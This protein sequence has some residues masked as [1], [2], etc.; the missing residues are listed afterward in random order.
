[1]K[2]A[3]ARSCRGVTLV[4]LLVVVAIVALIVGVS[5]PAATAGLDSVRMASTTDE[6]AALLNAAANR[7][8]RFQKPAEVVVIA[9]E[10]RLVLYG[11]GPGLPRELRMPEGI[12][13][14][15]VLAGQ[16]VDA[17]ATDRI[18]FVPGGTVPGFSIRLASRRGAHRR[19][20][21]DP[22]TGFPRVDSGENGNNGDGENG[23]NGEFK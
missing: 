10:G 23:G 18:L 9:A 19:V 13:I 22:M 7:A 12:V 11:A 16:G 14:E 15:A 2:G 8:E 21:L 17:V 20:R 4:E 3:R 5:L 1:M 6:V